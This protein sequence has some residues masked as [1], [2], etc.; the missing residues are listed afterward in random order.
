MEIVFKRKIG[1]IIDN[2][3]KYDKVHKYYF[4]SLSIAIKQYQFLEEGYD[5]LIKFDKK[6]KRITFQELQE[7]NI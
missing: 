1:E 6:W 2:G 3:I 7:M 4:L 5:I